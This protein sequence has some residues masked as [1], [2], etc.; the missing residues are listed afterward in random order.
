M[1]PYNLCYISDVIIGM[2]S[3]MLVELS[4]FGL[5][6]ISIQPSEH[7]KP[8]IDLGYNVKKIYSYKNL[9]NYKFKLKRKRKINK[10]YHFDALAKVK[11]IVNLNIQL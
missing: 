11:E 8:V 9:R 5:N 3:I 4:L 2:T 10:K 6:V 7:N 1:N